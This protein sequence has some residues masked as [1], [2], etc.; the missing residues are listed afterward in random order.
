MK[1][2]FRNDSFHDAWGF[3][4][5]KWRNPMGKKPLLFLDESSTSYCIKVSSF[6]PLL[7][8]FQLNSGGIWMLP[9]KLVFIGYPWLP[10][11][12][13]QWDTFQWSYCYCAVGKGVPG[14]RSRDNEGLS[15]SGW[16]V[17][18]GEHIRLFHGGRGPGF[19]R[20]SWRR[21]GKWIL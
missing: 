11:R 2:R 4:R 3:D 8:M 18:W 5:E 13:W 16:D 1:Q 7:L 6:K 12:R 20:C 10:L 15:M 14:F 9:G 19:G 21:P 17:I